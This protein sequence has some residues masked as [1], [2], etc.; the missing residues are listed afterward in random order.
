[1]NGLHEAEHHAAGRRADAPT[2][3]RSDETG[4]ADLLGAG[5][6]PAMAQAAELSA[7]GDQTQGGG[8]AEQAAMALNPQAYAT[9]QSVAPAA[10]GA[11]G[12]GIDDLVKT[13]GAAKTEA[14]RTA[15]VSALTTW[16]R[17]HLVDQTKLNDY[18]ARADVTAEDKTRILGELRVA[19]ARNEFLLGWSHHGGV[20]A[21]SKSGWET[22]GSNKGT[23]PTHYL[24][25]VKAADGQEW[26]TSFA[27]ATHARLGFNPGARDEAQFKSQKSWE[28][29]SGSVFW[30]GYRLRRWSRDGDENGGK[31]LTAAEDTVKQG[32][33]GSMLIDHPVWSALKTALDKAKEADRGATIDKTFEKHGTPRAG[34]VLILG[35]ANNFRKGAK[36]HTAL[37]ESY[38]A[39]SHSVY[40]IE[41]NT[42][43]AVRGRK[44]DLTDP[45]TV[46]QIVSVIR[47]GADFFPA[48]A[49]ANATAAGG[50]G[51][52]GELAG[53]PAGE[54][55]GP[56]PGPAPGMA[57]PAP[58]MA[59]PGMAGPAPGMAGPAPGTA[60]P[61]PA[62]AG[63]AAA[64]A[65][66]VD[67]A[68][69]INAKIAAVTRAQKWL[70][71]DSNDASA[72]AL[73]GGKADAD[74]SI[75]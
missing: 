56:G 31:P 15:A 26:C 69:A 74:A 71:G 36:S 2:G 39:A 43:Q 60:G 8:P 28:S 32:E 22:G 67:A 25:A 64:G 33:N 66:L 27:G 34:D 29:A 54:Q 9:A 38:D 48:E 47:V 11:A 42:S 6:L 5:G 53:E 68:K 12:G 59:G 13:L 1:M 7:A 72:F 35:T 65:A 45:D 55:Q 44:F 58:G 46:S 57:G 73:G 70:K 20:D 63:N 62:P 4:N 40:T 21:V 75:Q 30:S 52:A 50:E 10:A 17:T 61:A 37:I 18:L 24:G 19:I 23:F 16:C 14:E 3:Q 41:G 51:S 49:D